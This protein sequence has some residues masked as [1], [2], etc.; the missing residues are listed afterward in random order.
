MKYGKEDNA[1]RAASGVLYFS[2]LLHPR[3]LVAIRS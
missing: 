1:V 3:S 2:V